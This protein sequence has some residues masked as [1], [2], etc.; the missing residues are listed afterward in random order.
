MPWVS[1]YFVNNFAGGHLEVLVLVVSRPVVGVPLLE[2]V[3][4]HGVGRDVPEPGPYQPWQN[5]TQKRCNLQ[6]NSVQLNHN[7]AM[8]PPPSQ[9]QSRKESDKQYL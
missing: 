4:V 6:N 5:F 3:P 7:A 8:T 9:C 1:D 2:G